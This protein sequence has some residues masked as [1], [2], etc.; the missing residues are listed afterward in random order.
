MNDIT[1]KDLAYGRKLKLGAIAAPLVLLLVP[2]VITLVLMLISAGTPPAA[3]VV[4]FLGFIAMTVGFLS[5][6]VIA[7]I[8]TYKRTKW[9]RQMRERIA[10]DGIRADEIEWFIGEMKPSEKRALRDISSR[11]LLLGDAYRETLASRLTATRIIRNSRRELTMAKKRQNS[12]KQLRSA[13]SDEFQAQIGE[14][15]QKIDRIHT[16]AREMLAE[17]ES[18][19]A[20]IE[21][22]ASR[23]GG[24]ADNELALKKLTAR[25]NELPLALESAKVADE[26]R[27]ELEKHGLEPAINE[28]DA[29]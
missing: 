12:L 20:M 9:T 3:A 16:D 27:D 6:I 15:I 28:K 14:D 7:L 19:M 5:G 26:I 2:A 17:A 10:A 25:A 1:E 21:A 4:L 11:D 24:L 13:R 29:D 8:L 18:R 23:S 22:A